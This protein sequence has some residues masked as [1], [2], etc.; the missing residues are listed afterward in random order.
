MSIYAHASPANVLISVT[1]FAVVYYAATTIRAYYRLRHI[2]GPFWNSLSIF[3]LVGWHT[4]GSAIEVYGKTAEQYGGKLCRIGP[5]N[6]LT[7]SADQFRKMNAPRSPYRRS[8]WFNAMRMKPGSDNVL[9]MRDERRHDELRRKMAAGYS[10][11]EN[12]DLE[13]KIDARLKDF[14]DLIQRKY[15]ST[16]NSYRPMDFGRKA[17]FFTLDVISDLAFDKAFGDLKDD[18]DNFGYIYDT[19]ANFPT[20]IVMGVLP[21]LRDFLEKSKILNLLA[22]SAKDSTGLGSIIAVA[23]KVVAERFGSEKV[24]RQDMLGS[25][26]RHGLTQDEAESETVLQVSV[27]RPPQQIQSHEVHLLTRHPQAG[28][29]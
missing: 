3:P 13:E 20:M 25:F 24:D 10:G 23:Q 26:L 18:N 8:D 6:L 15:L 2:P 28:W 22:P 12:P 7:S 19:E 9:S 29:L 14:V 21:Q 16:S 17:Q 5:N 11:K 1:I 4:G 27:S